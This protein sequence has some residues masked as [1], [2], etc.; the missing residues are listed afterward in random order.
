MKKKILIISR[1]LPH[2]GGREIMV[3]KI[4]EYFSKNGSVCV[5]SPDKITQNNQN[6]NRINAINTNKTYKE[7][8]KWVKNEKPNIINCHTF[9]L[10]DLAIHISKKFS[11]PLV[12][13]LHGVFL[14]FYGKK[15]GN[16]LKR[17]YNNSNLVITVS[18]DYKNKLSKFLKTR[19]K[20]IICIQNG[21]DIKK[22]KI[23]LTKME[24]RKKYNLPLDKKIFVTPARMTYLKGLEYLMK[25]VNLIKDEKL[26]FLVTSPIGRFSDEERLYKQKLIEILGDNKKRVI[27]REYDNKD[28]NLVYDSVDFFILTSLV[29]G[30]SIALLEAMS[31]KI[32]VISTNTGG[33]VE[34]IKNGYN[35]WLIKPKNAQ[36]IVNAV[37]KVL[38]NKKIR[39]IAQRGFETAKIHFN[40]KKAL[41]RYN[42]AF[43]CV[44]K[45]YDNK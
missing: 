27:F 20:K 18:K 44:I 1:T 26:V 15:Y 25:A 37:Q 41:M 21:I 42:K 28:L 6:S 7:I 32:P 19:D 9:Y 14:D 5:V 24:V 45:N 39:L 34:V 12:F 31:K 16:L 43:N 23:S 38:D 2:L 8:E 30:I 29:E 35:G 40:L 13:T 33:S 22:K 11:I 36:E 17:I 10:S 4:I 3:E